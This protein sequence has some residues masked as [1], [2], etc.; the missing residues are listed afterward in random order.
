MAQHCWHLVRLETPL[1][2]NQASICMLSAITCFVGYYPRGECI[3]HTMVAAKQEHTHA[4]THSDTLTHTHTHTPTL[5]HTHAWIC[6]LREIEMNRMGW[7]TRKIQGNLLQKVSERSCGLIAPSRRQRLPSSRESPLRSFLSF[8]FKCRLLYLRFIPTASS[9]DCLM[10]RKMA[11]EGFF[12]CAQNTLVSVCFPGRSGLCIGYCLF[13]AD[14]RLPLECQS[15]YPVLSVLCAAVWDPEQPQDQHQRT[16]SSLGLQTYWTAALH[17][18]PS[19]PALS[20]EP[21]LRLELKMAP[22]PTLTFDLCTRL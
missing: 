6:T 1:S 19:L 7:L 22:R 2:L 5:W 11:F 12:L 13:W 10:T 4:R 18:L 8:K 15:K 16:F 9:T 21:A 17:P 14:K 3:A 20:R